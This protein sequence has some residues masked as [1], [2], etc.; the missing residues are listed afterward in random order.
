MKLHRYTQI[1]MPVDRYVSRLAPHSK[2]L[3]SL[4]EG[5][6]ILVLLVSLQFYVGK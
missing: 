4:L 1:I 6:L 5:G 2:K 3:V